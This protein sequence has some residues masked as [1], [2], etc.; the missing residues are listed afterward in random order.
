MIEVGTYVEHKQDNRK[1]VVVFD[2]Y[3]QEEEAVSV[4][5]GN[6]TSVEVVFVRE[7]KVLEKMQVEVS[8]KCM[9]CVFYFVVQCCRYSA[10]RHSRLI[11]HCQEEDKP[12]TPTQPYPDCQEANPLA[13]IRKRRS[14]W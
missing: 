13:F 5:F 3:N 10:S 7:L 9:G 12:W 4:D 8:G 11:A 14:G 1:G 2:P 6:S